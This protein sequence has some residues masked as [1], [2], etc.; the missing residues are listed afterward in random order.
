MTLPRRLLLLVAAALML[1]AMMAA[2]AA[3]AMARDFHDGI[4]DGRFLGDHHFLSDR[5]LDEEDDND[6]LVGDVFSLEEGE[7]VLVSRHTVICNVNG[8]IQRFH[9]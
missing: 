8:V 4:D 9:V 2:S 3:P 6:V 1:A 7:C 5:L